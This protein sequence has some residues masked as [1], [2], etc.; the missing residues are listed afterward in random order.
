MKPSTARSQRSIWAWLLLLCWFIAFAGTAASQTLANVTAAIAADTASVTPANAPPAIADNPPQSGERKS[1]KQPPK[2]AGPTVHEPGGRKITPKEAEE[3]FRSVDEIL[4]FASKDTGL[5]IKEPV[6]RKLADREE[7]ERYIERRMREDKDAQRLERSAASLKKFGLLPRDFQLRSF[8]LGLLKEQVAGF[9]DS[10]TKTVYLLN[11]VEAEAQKPVLAHE[12]THALQD[13]NFGLDK[14]MEDSKTA[15]SDQEELELEEAQSAREAVVEGQAMVVLLDY[16]LDPVG[17][18]VIDS[19][20]VIDAIKGEVLEA[21]QTPMFAKAPLFL[22]EALTFPYTY[23]LEFERQV[24]TKNGREAAY[25]GVFEKP[26]KNTR[27]IM[28][29]QTYLAGDAVPM[30]TVP[31]LDEVLKPAYKR[32]DFGALGQFDIEMLL[33]QWLGHRDP[34]ARS[35]RGGYYFTYENAANPGPPFAL[36]SVTRW[37][38]S[39]DARQFAGFYAASLAKRYGNVKELQPLRDGSGQWQTEEGPVDISVSGKYTV[40]I[41]SLP[42]GERIQVQQTIQKTLAADTH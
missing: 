33:W 22:R 41:E 30:L 42:A 8:L 39:D 17:R 35:W 24:L 1:E 29:P 3:L 36:V 12:L 27:Q 15:K 5:P 37:L 26:P 13:Q 32:Y 40:A 11:W 31:V 21:G 19:P 34:L 20:E 25:R 7:V 16:M 2:P 4:A 14:W 9:Y 38:T 10:K 23:G 18:T 6:K 28:Q